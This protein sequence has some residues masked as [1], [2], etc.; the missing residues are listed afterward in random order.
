MSL[1]GLVEK[2]AEVLFARHGLGPLNGEVLISVTAEPAFWCE[3]TCDTGPVKE[4][5]AALDVP[6]GGQSFWCGTAQARAAQK[7]RLMTMAGQQPPKHPTAGR[8]RMA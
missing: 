3:H 1:N 5:A 8:V 6:C 7:L 4:L 2:L